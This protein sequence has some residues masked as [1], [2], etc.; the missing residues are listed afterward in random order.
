MGWGEINTEVKLQEDKHI[1][2]TEYNWQIKFM[3]GMWIDGKKNREVT[4]QVLL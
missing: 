3:E 4:C 1:C 2:R